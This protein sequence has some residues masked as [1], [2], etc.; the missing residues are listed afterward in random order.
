MKTNNYSEIP[1]AGRIKRLR[2]AKGLSQKEF[3]DSLGIVQ[4]YLSCIE[5]GK[6]IPSHTFLMAL[7]HVYGV[8]E[9]WLFGGTD[10]ADEEV[11][12]K[13][14]STT[15][16]R[17]GNIPLLKTNVQGFPDEVREEDISDHLSLPD[18]PDGCYAIVAE[19]DFMAPTIRHG[20]LVI[21]KPG[22]EL[23]N[24]SIVLLNNKWGEV[25]LRR[26]R[27]TGTGTWFSPENSAYTPFN[28]DANTRIFG[29]VTDV[30]RKVTL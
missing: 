9:G 26:C 11:Q 14:F 23:T 17:T 16:E 13:K 3:A 4:G 2:Q 15:A 27:M 24:R 29:T 22:S 30:W 8:N 20:D 21:F 1:L 25:I 6:K 10:Q 19:G 12:L 18:I 28:L 5:R 7:C